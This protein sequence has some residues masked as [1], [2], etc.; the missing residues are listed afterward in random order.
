[1]NVLFNEQNKINHSPIR[2]LFNREFYRV[3]VLF[4]ILNSMG[5]LSKF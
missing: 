2:N 5:K 3:K 4:G 1:L